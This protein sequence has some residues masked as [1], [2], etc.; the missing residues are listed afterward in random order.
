MIHTTFV[1][2]GVRGERRSHDTDDVVVALREAAG[3]WYGESGR[4]Y[5]EESVVFAVV[6]E[7][8]GHRLSRADVARALRDVWSIEEHRAYRESLE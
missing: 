4:K 5:P 7:R 6:V 1:A 8:D 2:S 3:E